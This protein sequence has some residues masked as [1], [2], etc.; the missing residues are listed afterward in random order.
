MPA[1]YAGMPADALVAFCG[2]YLEILLYESSIQ[3]IR[4]STAESARFP[5]GAASYFDV[6]FTE[7]HARLR[8]Y[9]AA[10]FRAST[11]TSDRLV[12]TLLG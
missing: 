2:R 8:G 1:D 12:Q 3:T 11:E 6:V 10:T 9:V 7:V 4:L 5:E